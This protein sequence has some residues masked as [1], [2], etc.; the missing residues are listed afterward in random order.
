MKSSSPVEPVQ[1]KKT[2]STNGQHL[3]TYRQ[4]RQINIKLWAKSMQDNAT[5][6]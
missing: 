2:R 4:E 1:E 3:R 5:F 6:D